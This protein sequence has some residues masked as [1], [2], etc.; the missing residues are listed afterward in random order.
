M[1]IAVTYDEGQVWQHFGKTQNFKVYEALNG[2]ITGSAVIDTGGASHGALAAFL[3]QQ[4]IDVV[5]CGGV[6]APM[7]EK[8]EVMGMQVVP[9]VSGNAD[10]AVQAFLAGKFKGDRTAIHE[11][12]HHNH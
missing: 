8:L 5:V 6:G 2:E 12:C 9:G 3:S 1:K 10:E 7:V 11:G 4:G